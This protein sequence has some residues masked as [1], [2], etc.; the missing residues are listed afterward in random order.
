[1][2]NQQQNDAFEQLVSEAVNNIGV[3]RDKAM[4]EHIGGMTHEELDQLLHPK[5]KRRA[6]IMTIVRLAAAC[7]AVLV[8]IIAVGQLDLGGNTRYGNASLFN[9][10]YKE[11]RMD[12]TSFDAAGDH[13]N[14][15]GGKS[16]AAYIEEAS[17]L[18][19]KKHSKHDLR[20]GITLLERLL[21]YNYKP[22]LANEIHWYLG[23]GYL[24]D[25]RTD[26]AKSELRMVIDL[27]K[28]RA[29]N[30]H[31]SDAQDIIR[32]MER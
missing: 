10:Y 25:N 7:A 27:E 28:A 26:K 3:K 2:N 30:V 1:M 13:I 18:I 22:S 8:I 32:Q 19:N 24:K 14:A 16:T 15:M 17:T 11:Y 12:A 4:I 29:I 9:T 6:T 5:R 31:T 23:L 21:T 20:R